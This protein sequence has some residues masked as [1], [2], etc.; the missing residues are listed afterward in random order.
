MKKSEMTVSMPLTAYN[1]Y[2]TY[3]EKYIVLVQK[4]Q[5]CFDDSLLNAGA[6]A[7]IDFDGRK[8]LAVAREFLPSRFASMDIAVRV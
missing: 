4:L 5:D 2:E 6:A 8:A 7:T 1:E 3:R